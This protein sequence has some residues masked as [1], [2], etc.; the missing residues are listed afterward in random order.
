MGTRRRMLL[1][2]SFS[3]NGYS[4]MICVYDSAVIWRVQY[5]GRWVDY[6][7]DLG[8]QVWVELNPP[9]TD[10]QYR[11]QL[12]SGQEKK[13]IILPWRN[14][15]ENNIYFIGHGNNLSAINRE[16]MYREWHKTLPSEISRIGL[17]RIVVN[18]Q[19]QEAIGV[20]TIGGEIHYLR[21][22]FGD[23][24]APDPPSTF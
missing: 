17:E 15:S 8:E 3:Q 6:S 24:L 4:F 11:N 22:S 5:R 2:E 10:A 13:P 16:A 23:I 20:R 19:P 7:R 18:N 9:M 1:K 14:P 12:N 21:M